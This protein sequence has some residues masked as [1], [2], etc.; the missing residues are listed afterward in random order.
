MQ[1]LLAQQ[2]LQGKIVELGENRATG[3][4]GVE[5]SVLG[6]DDDITDQQGAFLLHLPDNWQQTTVTLKNSAL[7]IIRPAMGEVAL[8]APQGLEIQVCGAEK[9]RLLKKVDALESEVKKL[10][11]DRSLSQQQIARLHGQMLDTILHYE[12]ELEVKEADLAKAKADSGAKSAEI[13]ALS[14]TVADLE[15][16]V[17]KLERQLQ[18]ALEEKFRQQKKQLDQVSAALE[19]YADQVK[20]L[21]DMLLPERLGPYFLNEGARAKLYAAIEKYNAART[22]MLEGQ[23]GWQA[24]IAHYWEDEGLPD[25]FASTCRYLLDEVHD[26]GVY[27]MEFSVMDPLKQFLGRQSNRIRAEKQ[28]KEASQAAMPSLDAKIPVLEA[29]IKDLLALLRETI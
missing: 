8:P 20:N 15:E 26:Q 10:R 16:Q 9:K 6:Y 21:R 4:P 11:K 27:P 17:G 29:K 2:A 12:R 24:G 28:A 18:A 23:E 19:D 25:Q 13:E 1:P 14:K 5:V 7:R 22:A 3:V